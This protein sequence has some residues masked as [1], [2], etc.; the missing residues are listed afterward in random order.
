MKPITYSEDMAA[1]VFLDL[2]TET[3]R[4]AKISRDTCG[5]PIMPGDPRMK[6][7]Y[8]KPGDQLWVREPY[9]QFG[10]WEPIPGQLTKGGK[11]KWEFIGHDHNGCIFEAPAE[12]RKGRHHKDPATPAWHKRLARFMP[13]KFSRTTLEIT[14]TRA[15]RLH[16]ITERS[17]FA[18]GMKPSRQ[19][20]SGSWMVAGPSLGGTYRE[21]FRYVWSRINDPESWDENPFVWVIQFRKI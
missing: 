21:G 1:A 17:A 4:I 16:N 15:E 20:P 3:R 19:C 14:A 5:D 12:Y 11:Q 10:H 13:R 18:E 8:G 9:Y 7:P 6:C 2:K